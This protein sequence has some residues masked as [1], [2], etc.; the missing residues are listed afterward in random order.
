MSIRDAASDILFSRNV[1]KNISGILMTLFLVAFPLSLLVYITRSYGESLEIKL[2]L[3][4]VLIISSA[5]IASYGAYAMTY[6]KITP[7]ILALST[8]F[9]A[10]LSSGIW[11]GMLLPP[12]LYKVIP[13]MTALTFYL[14]GGIIYGA[15][16]AATLHEDSQTESFYMMLVYGIVSELVYPNVFW[17]LYYLAWGSALQLLKN[18]LRYLRNE[19]ILVIILSFFFG[20]FGAALAKCYIIINWGSWDPLFKSIPASFL[21]GLF[22]TIGGSI[23]YKIGKTIQSLPV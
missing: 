9:G 7:K 16:I 4:L 23:G 12:F 13:V 10:L 19:Y 3:A 22:A 2:R 1:Y 8:I 14:P 6:Y 17:F 11:W 20:Y 15:L 18:N 5:M 21:D